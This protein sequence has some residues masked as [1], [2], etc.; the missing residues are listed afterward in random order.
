LAGALTLLAGGEDSGLPQFTAAVALYLFGMGLVNPL[1]TAMALGPF[2]RQAGL[3]SSLL[4]CLQMA[5]AGGMTALASLAGGS[6]ATTLGLVL[7]AASMLAF[8]ALMAR[9]RQG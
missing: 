1:G 2:S 6:P 7:V 8:V 4:G 9:R 3:A 5:C